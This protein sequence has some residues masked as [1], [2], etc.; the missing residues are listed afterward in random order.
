V[1]FDGKPLEDGTIEFQPSGAGGAVAAGGVISRGQF[2]IPRAEGP[3]PGKYNVA[4]YD[5]ANTRTTGSAE[6]V[7]SVAGAR[8]SLADLRGTIPPRY[9]SATELTADVMPGGLNRFTFDL[10]K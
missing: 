5:Q 8:K 10:K 9:N 1:T 3:V 6:G 7:A 4:I 2:A